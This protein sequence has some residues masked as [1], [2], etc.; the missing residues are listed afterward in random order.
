MMQLTADVSELIKFG[1][2][3]IVDSSDE[4]VGCRRITRATSA[5]HHDEAMVFRESVRIDHIPKL[6]RKLQ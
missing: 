2:M 6:A 4:R 5:R 3:R 1:S